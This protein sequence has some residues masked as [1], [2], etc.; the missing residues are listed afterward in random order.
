M[1]YKLIGEYPFD[2]PH[3]F[4]G[5]P[6][7]NHG[8][9]ATLEDR[10]F[11][12][13]DNS[14]EKIG[15]W[16]Q[17]VSA[18]FSLAATTAQGPLHRDL[19]PHNFAQPSYM[20]ACQSPNQ[21]HRDRIAEFIRRAQLRSL[22]GLGLLR[23][24]VPAA[25]IDRVAFVKLVHK[26]TQAKSYKRVRRTVK[27]PRAALALEGY[28][29]SIKRGAERF[30]NAP[31]FQFNFIVSRSLAGPFSDD[32]IST[33][34]LSDITTWEDFLKRGFVKTTD[35]DNPDRKAPRGKT[36]GQKANDNDDY[37]DDPNFTVQGIVNNLPESLTGEPDKVTFLD[38]LPK[39]R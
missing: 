29:Q 13:A 15:L 39:S 33:G 23:I 16:V 3:E 25:G 38:F 10:S 27:G 1:A 24:Y 8:T 34:V 9:N 6:E 35:P 30:K 32:P 28:V 4:V 19:Y 31:D 21:E 37:A 7:L 12:H 11:Q 26:Q 18:D 22:Q 36:G 5:L 17:E 14:F 2:K 20:F